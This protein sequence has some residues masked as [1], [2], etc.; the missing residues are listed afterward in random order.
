M[1][2][3]EASRKK[4][5]NT[6][7]NIGGTSSATNSKKNTVRI[8]WK[9]LNSVT[10]FDLLL[11]RWLRTKKQSIQRSDGKKTTQERIDMEVDESLP[12]TTTQS[13]P[14]EEQQE[15]EV[16]HDNAILMG[17]D[18]ELVDALAT[19]NNQQRFFLVQRDPLEDEYDNTC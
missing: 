7:E 8:N 18:P 16:E 17:H 1:D 13:E 9:A 14:S 10:R 2:D 12:Q 15:N 3:L 5:K 11:R 19:F 6:N 4:K